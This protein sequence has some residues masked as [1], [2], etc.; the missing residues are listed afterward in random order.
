MAKYL[1]PA[2]GF[3]IASYLGSFDIA[4]TFR[5]PIRETTAVEVFIRPVAELSTDITKTITLRVI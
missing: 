2:D 4:E 5:P 1:L 3:V